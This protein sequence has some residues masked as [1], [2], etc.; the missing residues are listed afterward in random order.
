MVIKNCWERQGDGVV[1]VGDSGREAVRKMRGFRG[2]KES[3][4]KRKK[5]VIERVKKKEGQRKQGR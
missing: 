3:V 5:K 2:L 4:I 1:Y